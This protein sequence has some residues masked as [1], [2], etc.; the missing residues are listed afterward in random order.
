MDNLLIV[1]AFGLG[2]FYP[3]LLLK[4]ILLIVVIGG[5]GFIFLATWFMNPVVALGCGAFMI[6]FVIHCY[7]TNEGANK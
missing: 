7:R 5:T 1:L 2:L 4:V 3:L 6:G